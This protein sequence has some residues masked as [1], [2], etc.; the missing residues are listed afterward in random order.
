MDMNAHFT[1]EESPV[2]PVSTGAYRE[3][4]R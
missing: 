3:G 2:A 1:S 4:V